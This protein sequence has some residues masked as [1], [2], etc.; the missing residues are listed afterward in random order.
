[1]NARIRLTAIA[2][3]WGSIALIP[4][5]TSAQ[6]L[7][8]VVRHA[9]R[10]DGGAGSM[11]AQTDPPLS[12]AGEARAQKLAAMLA[13]ADIRGIYTS[14]FVRTKQTAQPLSVKLN[15][16]VTASPSANVDA[17]VAR[18]KREHPDDIV[19][20]VG[21]SNTIPAIVKA[22]GGGDITVADDD[23]ASLFVVS[24]A[25]RTATRLRFIP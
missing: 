15:V 10:A 11:N 3:L 21:H 19:L 2:W 8:Y 23:Y 17:L 24:P 20:I 7:V 22:L 16:P 1:M 12:A 6:A 14:E 4:A 5:S 13:D 18:V 9:E 25:S